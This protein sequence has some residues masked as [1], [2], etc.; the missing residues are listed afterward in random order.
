[1][2][3]ATTPL[4]SRTNHLL[5]ARE[6]VVMAA[7]FDARSLKLGAAVPVLKSGSVGQGHS[8]LLNIRLSPSGT[9]LLASS[10]FNQNRVVSVGRDGAAL[11]LDLPSARYSTPRT[12]PD[13]RLL[14]VENEGS[15]L[16]ALDLQRGTRSRL[17]PVAIGTSFPT[18]TSD[19]KRVV[20]RRFNVPFWAAADGGGADGLLGAAFGNNDFPVSPGPD[21][22]SI[23]MVRIH[24]E[25]SAD[26]VLVSL[27]SR[28]EPRPLV[29]TPAYEGGASLSSDGRWLLYQSNES[30]RA[31]IYVKPYPALNR[32]YQISEG[33]G[34][35][36]RW[37]RSSR[38]IFYRSGQS[39][40][41]TPFEIAANEFV[42][43]KPK[44][45][46]LD[47]QYDF[48]QGTSVPNY[49]VTADGRFI[50]LRRDPQGG[51]LRVVLN[52]TDELSRIV[53]AGGVR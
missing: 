28:F 16:E 21:A 5:F 12:S 3:R 19:G 6:G 45:L 52:W 15:V 24:P 53:A 47:D 9:L 48:G 37:S 51:N 18:W 40:T 20:M 27:A 10:D 31:E 7:P 14:L 23:L 13:G 35:Q 17:G 30:G 34:V 29:A 50:L 36:P 46:F 4:W 8:G 41:A 39:V 26:V 42:V 2:E 44:A 33:G 43:G 32:R 38:E 25:T 49:D 1:M 22:E 11:S